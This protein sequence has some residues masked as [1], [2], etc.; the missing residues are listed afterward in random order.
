MKLKF[1]LLVSLVF[2]ILNYVVMEFLTTVWPS[3]TVLADGYGITFQVSAFAGYNILGLFSMLFFLLFLVHS[4]RCVRYKV[5]PAIVIA[6]CGVVLAFYVF[7]SIIYIGV[8][9]QYGGQHVV[10][11]YIFTSGVCSLLLNDALRTTF[12][13]VY[14][15]I[16]PIMY[17]FLAVQVLC[18]KNL[19]PLTRVVGVLA[20]SSFVINDVLLLSC[21]YS[22]YEYFGVGFKVFAYLYVV[23][24]ALLSMN[25]YML[26]EKK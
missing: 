23:T 6:L 22:Y 20:F 10:D 17:A 7:E 8:N 1:Y 25:A 24:L 15:I 3:V 12:D 5:I 2:Y 13:I 14:N 21:G 16:E 19:V 18:M 4:R 9:S 11:E 26:L